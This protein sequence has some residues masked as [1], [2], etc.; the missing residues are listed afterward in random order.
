MG[1]GHHLVPKLE[2]ALSLPGAEGLNI[3]LV[4]R[5]VSAMRNGL[6]LILGRVARAQARGGPLDLLRGARNM[7][8]ERIARLTLAKV[9]GLD[10]EESDAALLPLEVDEGGGDEE[11]VGL[12]MGAR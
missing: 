5:R 9:L 3:D 8:S 7:V 2:P 10:A 12:K 6:L 1:D 11:P 4:L